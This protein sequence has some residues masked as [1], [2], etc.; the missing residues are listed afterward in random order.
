M[1]ARL[2]RTTQQHADVLDIYPT[3]SDIMA[4]LWPQAN[5]RQQQP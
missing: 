5:A 2:D 4:D 1:L 3:V